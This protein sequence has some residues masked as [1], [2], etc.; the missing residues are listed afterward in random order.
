MAVLHS[1]G[2]IYYLP[3]LLLGGRFSGMSV[4]LICAPLIVRIR[5]V[6]K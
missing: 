3:A 4:G 1:V 2:L 5:K 6:K